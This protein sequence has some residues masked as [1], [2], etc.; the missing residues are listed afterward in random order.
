M[1]I[2]LGVVIIIAILCLSLGIVFFLGRRLFGAT[3][4]QEWEGFKRSVL[5]VLWV[6]GLIFILPGLIN[7]VFN[8]FHHVI[9]GTMS[10]R[11]YLKHINEF[12]FGGVYN[13]YSHLFSRLPKS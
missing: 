1:N 3:K 12:S 8:F 4:D 13:F 10:F 11:E 7:L 6:F 5:G 2:F 9:W